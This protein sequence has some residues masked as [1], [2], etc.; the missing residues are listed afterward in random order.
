KV[1]LGGC[2]FP[3][4]KVNGVSGRVTVQTNLGAGPYDLSTVS[5]SISLV[6]PEDANCAVDASAVSGRF[7][8]DLKISK[9]VVRRNHWRVKF[10]QGGTHIRM[11]SVSGKMRLL[12]A[13]DASGKTPQDTGGRVQASNEGRTKI[14]ERLSEG[15]IDV[16]QAV[17]ELGG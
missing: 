13:L 7:V 15:E 3:T 2:D 5:G 8:T 4:L 16:E 12:S 1:D 17:Q 14:L 11:K 6:I 9:S 10:G